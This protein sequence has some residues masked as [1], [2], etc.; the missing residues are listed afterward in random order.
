MPT[1]TAY[2]RSTLVRSLCKWYIR[3]RTPELYHLQSI[4]ARGVFFIP[5]F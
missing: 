3:L 1:G 4:L 2:H 5:I